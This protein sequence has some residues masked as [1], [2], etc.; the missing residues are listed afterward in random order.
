[1][2]LAHL[3][4]NI[5]R[6]SAKP[7]TA[8]FVTRGIACVA[9]MSFALRNAAKPTTSKYSVRNAKLPCKGNVLIAVSHLRH[10]AEMQN[11]VVQLVNS[12][13]TEPTRR[14]GRSENKEPTG[15]TIF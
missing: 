12:E 8:M 7:V 13:L 3:I 2:S 10:D 1:M 4:V 6:A 14:K 15:R 9:S 5:M 11:S